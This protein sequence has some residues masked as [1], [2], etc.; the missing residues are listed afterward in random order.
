[1]KAI[2]A[3]DHD[4]APNTY[5]GIIV[6]ASPSSV[7]PAGTFA[8]GDPVCDFYDAVVFMNEFYDWHMVSSSVDHF[9][10]DQPGYRWDDNTGLLIADISQLNVS[11]LGKETE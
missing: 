6:K 4:E 2:L 3:I 7:G 1:M 9:V 8:T 5:R 10:N 11:L